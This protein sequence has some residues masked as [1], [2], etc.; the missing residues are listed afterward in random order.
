[1]D[2]WM[3]GW[4]DE[5]P[6]RGFIIVI[7]TFSLKGGHQRRLLPYL[8]RFTLRGP[9][10]GEGRSREGGGGWEGTSLAWHCIACPRL[11]FRHPGPYIHR[12]VRRR[13]DGR[14][15]MAR[16]NIPN[17]FFV[18]FVYASRGALFCSFCRSDMAD[19]AELCRA[20]T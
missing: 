1:M 16:G 15:A 4:M 18:H 14:S 17:G 2:G 20:G 9:G 7:R 3:D 12:S 5:W 13:N 11:M 10:R 6:G 19:G 8:F